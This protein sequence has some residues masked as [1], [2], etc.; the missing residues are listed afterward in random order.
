MPSGT[1]WIAMAI[2]SEM[3]T[4]GSSSV[5]TNVA[6]PSGKLCRPMARAVM[7]PMRLSF[8]SSDCSAFFIARKPKS[9]FV[10]SS[11]AFR[12]RGKSS[13]IASIVFASPGDSL[14]DS[15]C[16]GDELAVG[17]SGGSGCTVS[18]TTSCTIRGSTVAWQVGFVVLGQLRPSRLQEVHK[19][20]QE[21][22]EKHATEEAQ[23][24]VEVGLVFGMASVLEG[25]VGLLEDLNEGHVEHDAGGHSEGPGQELL[26]GQL[27]QALGEHDGCM[28]TT[29]RRS[30]ERRPAER[31]EC[32]CADARGGA[33]EADEAEAQTG[34]V[35]VDAH[36]EQQS[37][38]AAVVPVLCRGS[39][40]E[41]AGIRCEK[42][43][44]RRRLEG[45]LRRGTNQRRQMQWHYLC[46][47]GGSLNCACTIPC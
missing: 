30:G 18:R 10:S 13:S 25:L 2:A 38:R 35:A 19:A 26:V 31:R 8:A 6:R 21:G 9:C 45:A 4:L 20:V 33:C 36:P 12:R 1:L 3:P 34:I 11:A 14:G 16:A 37:L 46:F 24:C 47:R 44:W 32:T 29:E 7:T 43:Q 15:S 39:K 17:T 40:Q 23:R 42:R 22:V 41:E 27:H 28:K 5:A